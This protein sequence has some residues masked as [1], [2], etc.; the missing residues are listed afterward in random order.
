MNELPPSVTLVE[1]GGLGAVLGKQAATLARE[2]V[3]RE[4]A[5]LSAARDVLQSALRDRKDLLDPFAPPRER[6]RAV[7]EALR[8]EIAEHRRHGGVLAR[9]PTD[10]TTLL[11]IFAATLGWGPAQRYLDDPRVN[12]IK[13]IGTAIR[14]QEMGKPFVTVPE[15]FAH[16]AEVRSRVDLLVSLLGVRLDADHPQATIPVA[17][18]TRMHVTIPPRTANDD[19]LVCIRRGRTSA[20]DLHELLSRGTLDSAVLDLLLALCRAR[21]SF[22]IAGSTGAGKT[23]LLESLA[24]SWPGE[25]HVITIEDHT[26]EIGIRRTD[27]WTRE[28]VDT[29]RDPQAFGRVAREALRQTP[30][31]VLPGEIRGNEAGAVLRLALSDHPVITTVHARSCAEALEQFASYAAL[32]GAYMYDNQRLLALRDTCT[33]FEVVIKVDFWEAL[34]RRV[35]SEVALCAGVE[36]V[37]AELRPRLLPLVTV[38]VVEDQVQ[39]RCHAQLTAAHELVWQD[40]RS[41]TPPALQAKLQR[42]RV[43][44]A[45]ERGATSLRLVDEALQRADT[46]ILAG[47]PTRAIATLRNAWQHRRDSRVLH[48]C[49]RAL[50]LDPAL[51][52]TE[53]AMATAAREALAQLMAA[54]QWEAAWQALHDLESNL[55]QAAA[56]QPPEGWDAWRARIQEGLARLTQAREAVLVTDQLLAQGQ[57]RAALE[58]LSR[59]EDGAISDADA[60][61][62]VLARAR[63]LETLQ[64]QGEATPAMVAAVQAQRQALEAALRRQTGGGASTTPV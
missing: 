29:V 40:S 57:A 20:W 51:F 39:W 26:A 30:D 41:Q 63:V 49:A 36:Q 28:M 35:I 64:A 48:L 4:S 31:L 61:Q 19:L 7:L 16:A 38:Q 17:H 15:R 54:R 55:V 44:A 10:D 42:A 56:A 32:P 9:V 25:P 53:A 5:I 45:L 22:L 43:V 24:N 3:L 27:L 2:A 18:G 50:H 6:R 62:V 60:L 14:V 23:A 47:E 21:C 34:G 8:G 37:G 33:A 52:A 1:D 46:L 13:I 12:E 58:R 11:E 59:I